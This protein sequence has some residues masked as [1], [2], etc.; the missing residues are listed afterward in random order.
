MKKNWIKSV[1]GLKILLENPFAA[2]QRKQG[3]LKFQFCSVYEKELQCVNVNILRRCKKCLRNNRGNFRH[4]FGSEEV[5]VIFGPT[6]Y[7]TN[8]NASSTR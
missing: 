1:V 8:P 3:D 5:F 7:A 4:L 6:D 2:L